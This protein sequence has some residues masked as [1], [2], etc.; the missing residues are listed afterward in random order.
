MSSFSGWYVG[1][2][3]VSTQT[4]FVSPDPVSIARSPV[5]VRVLWEQ[6]MCQLA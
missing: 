3:A 6:R 1:C 5:S 2:S 4:D